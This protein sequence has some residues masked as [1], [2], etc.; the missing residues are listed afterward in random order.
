MI[1]KVRSRFP[2]SVSGRQTIPGGR[3]LLSDVRLSFIRGAKIG[4]LGVNGSGKSTLLKVISGTTN[5][6]HITHQAFPLRR[7]LSRSHYGLFTQL[8][9][10]T[11]TNKV[12]LEVPLKTVRAVCW[13][14]GVDS[15]VVGDVWRRPGLKFKY[16]TQEPQLDYDLDVQGTQWGDTK[17][18]RAPAYKAAV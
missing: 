6:F 5:L 3:T 7:S 1:C 13:F 12:L 18:S 4:V 17:E 9:E 15:D 14:P 11:H 2:L 16:L 10:D 8:V